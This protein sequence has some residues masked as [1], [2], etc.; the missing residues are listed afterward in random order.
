[1]SLKTK[2]SRYSQNETWCYNR[3]QSFRNLAILFSEH[4]MQSLQTPPPEITMGIYKLVEHLLQ[5]LYPQQEVT[6]RGIIR[7]AIAHRQVVTLDKRFAIGKYELSSKAQQLFNLFAKLYFYQY[8]GGLSAYYTE[9]YL[10][11][12]QHIFSSFKSN[13]GGYTSAQKHVA[14]GVF[15][16]GRDIIEVVNAF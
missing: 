7:L 8:K 12:L 5:T 15:K 10:G 4:L 11:V 9:V 13:P 1:M 2:L 3:G 16:K 14:R 6:T